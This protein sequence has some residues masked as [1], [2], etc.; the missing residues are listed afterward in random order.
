[1]TLRHAS[2]MQYA[3]EIGCGIC[4]WKARFHYV[5]MKWFTCASPEC[6][7]V[8][9]QYLCTFFQISIYIYS[10][11]DTVHSLDT[12]CVC[13]CL[14]A[15]VCAF[16]WARVCVCAYVIYACIIYTERGKERER[17]V[18]QIC[19]CGDG[20]NQFSEVKI[21]RLQAGCSYQQTYMIMFLFEHR[22]YII[23]SYKT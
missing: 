22:I 18:G 7:T 13:L 5:N 6:F 15:R 21:L 16:A 1:M 11:I 9:I 12:M 23:Y 20:E 8:T 10:S 17:V 2:D 3:N 4:L 14:W 19:D